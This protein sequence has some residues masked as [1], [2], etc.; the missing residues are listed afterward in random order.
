MNSVDS[1]VKKYKCK[2]VAKYV[3]EIII[4]PPQPQLFLVF[5]YVP[6]P[7]TTTTS[8]TTTNKWNNASSQGFLCSSCS[9]GRN[10]SEKEKK[11]VIRGGGPPKIA[12]ISLGGLLKSN[13]YGGQ[14]IISHSS[15][16]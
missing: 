13:M 11:N 16:M 14:V 2:V 1:F 10:S 7:K 12:S 5:K 4:C 8:K 3:F 6:P 9:R 15:I